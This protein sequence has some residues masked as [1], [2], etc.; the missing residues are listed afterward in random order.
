MRIFAG[1]DTVAAARSVKPRLDD[2]WLKTSTVLVANWKVVGTYLLLPNLP[3]S[4][5]NV[6]KR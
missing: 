5:S 6:D 4:V 3:T 1:D 2:N